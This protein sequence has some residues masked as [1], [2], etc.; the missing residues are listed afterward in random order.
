MGQAQGGAPSCHENFGISTAITPSHCQSDGQIAI[1]LTG[2]HS[3][4]YNFQYALQPMVA[5]GFS[6]GATSQ[7]TLTGIPPGTYTLLVSAVCKED[8]NNH[9]IK[10]F[11]DIVVPGTYKP[12]TVGYNQTLSRAS[13]T[14]CATGRIALTVKEGNGNYRFRIVQAPAGVPVPQEV[15]PNKTGDNYTLPTNNFPAGE[16]RIE[17]SDDCYTASATLTLGTLTTHPS[18][19][20]ENATMFTP[21]PVETYDCSVLRAYVSIASSINN[22]VELKKYV[23]EGLF[24][25][26]MAPAGGTPTNWQPLPI[27]TKLSFDMAPNKASDFYTAN[28]LEMHI[29]STLCPTYVRKKPFNVKRPYITQDTQNS[30]DCLEKTIKLRPWTD[31]DGI[32]CFPLKVTVRKGGNQGPIHAE[33]TIQNHT[34]RPSFS[35]PFQ[36]GNYHVHLTDNE[37]KFV[38]TSSYS[39]NYELSFS[40]IEHLCNAYKENVNPSSFTNCLP[41]TIDVVEANTTPEKVVC[42]L[43][44]TQATYQKTCPLEYNKD[45]IYRLRREGEPNTLYTLTRKQ[46]PPNET[47][48]MRPYAPDECKAEWGTFDISKSSS[49]RAETVLTLTGPAGFEPQTIKPGFTNSRIYTPKAYMPAGLYTLT[50][51]DNCGT[52]TTTYDHKGFYQVRDFT[53]TSQLT[54]SGLVIKPSATMTNNG[55]TR[56]PNFRIL[57]GPA[58]GYTSQAIAAG[59]T[60]TLS[61]EGTYVLGV[62]VSQSY[63]ACAIATLVVEYKRPPLQLSTTHTAAYVCSAEDLNGHIIVKAENGVEPYTYELWNEDNTTK[64]D[65]P[66]TVEPSGAWHYLY[67]KANDVF[68]IRMQDA[69]GYRFA[70]QVTLVNMKTAIVAA[71][72]R[73]VI[74]AGESIELLSLPFDTYKWYR[75]DGTLLSTEQNPIITNA[76]PSM[77]GMYRVV[78]QS[79]QCGTELEGFIRVNV[80]PCY[81]P[82]NP[83]LMHRSTPW[84]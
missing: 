41:V 49:V 80:L 81:A 37:G 54:C 38:W 29:R 36:T 51:T 16:Y 63:N 73:P 64:I 12:I 31:Y 53:Y 8:E 61:V 58:G 84:Q 34:D 77:S 25:I 21:N 24:E 43:R 55:A 4:F 52:R 78:V 10:T 26:G 2:D 19:G 11:S 83:Q 48:T 82:V 45:Y 69:C 3:N 6:I 46:G 17:V 22:D 72:R 39:S 66:H 18:L 14:G 75:P 50:A 42:T 15:V 20:N 32:Y 5:G 62:C 30:G 27:N 13:L 70:Q 68:T 65:I 47:Y 33:F 60:F 67:G 28:S 56:T 76:K 59:G 7:S 35:I 57:S 1:T 23:E 79:H 40:T 74:C 44:Y 71:V 9:V